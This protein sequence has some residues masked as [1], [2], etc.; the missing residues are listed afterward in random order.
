MAD[1]GPTIVNSDRSGNGGW[2]IALFIALVALVALLMF[3]GII[4]IG[5][6]NGSTDV[7]VN[8]PAVETPATDKTA[9][10]PATPAN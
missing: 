3:T 2:A 8:V 1:R 6:S 5:G 4:E 7:N 10:T 9:A